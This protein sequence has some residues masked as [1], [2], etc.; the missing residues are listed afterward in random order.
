MAEAAHR[1][2][3][4]LL[5]GAVALGIGNDPEAAPPPPTEAAAA[6]AQDLAGA[7]HPHPA[8]WRLILNEPF[9]GT[10]LNT[11]RWAR[12]FWWVQGGGCTI[13]SNHELEWYQKG[14]V[15]VSGGALHLEARRE[16]TEAPSGQVFPYSSG[17]ISSGPRASRGAALFGFRYGYVEAR[18]RL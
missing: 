6:Q 7:P 9:D 14:N 12:C 2:L 11:S 4:A 17:M 3:G 1:A 5:L 18:L 15:S 8:S 16:D 13:A 10:A